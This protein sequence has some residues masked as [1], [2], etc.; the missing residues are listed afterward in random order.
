MAGKL[1]SGN[2]RVE[3]S[4]GAYGVRPSGKMHYGIDVDTTDPDKNVYATTPGTCTESAIYYKPDVRWGFGNFVRI[5][6]ASG[7]EHYYAHLASR[8]VKRGDYVKVGQA[9]GIMGKTGNAG[10][11]A[12]AEHVHYEVR[13][14]PYES[15]AINPA[16]YA[17]IENK[18]GIYPGF[19]GGRVG[20]TSARDVNAPQLEV[21]GEAIN[22]RKGP[23]LKYDALGFAN[24]GYYYVG[25]VEPVTA[26]GYAWYKIQ[27][28]PELWIAGVPGVEYL[29]A[30]GHV[31]IMSTKPVAMRLGPMTGGDLNTIKALLDGLKIENHINDS[32]I[33]TA[34]VS[35]GDQNTILQKCTGLGLG[36]GPLCQGS[37]DCDEIKKQIE[38]LTA[39]N[40]ALEAKINAAIKALA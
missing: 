20:I 4:Y 22:A 28:N 18:Q 26:D 23:G 2:N 11:D 32:L 12:Q 19:G 35:V 34:P 25:N 15:S 13:T 24:L 33:D 21:T 17:G 7:K 3:V 8:A 37:E 30:G 9:V 29:P 16:S 5:K 27:E 10:L 40:V 14:G 38:A 36:F 1:F 6:D 31:M 39:E